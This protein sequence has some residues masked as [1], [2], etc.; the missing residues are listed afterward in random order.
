MGLSL[1]CSKRK[2][3]LVTIPFKIPFSSTI[4]IPPILCSR[5]ALLASATTAVNGNV[6]GSII[7]PLSA[8]F[9]LRTLAACCS[10][11]MFLCS[12]PIPPSLAMAIAIL[13]SVT[14]SIA[15]DTTGILIV[16][17]FVN[18]A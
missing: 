15:A 6:T 9:T 14:V 4:G 2:S 12:T 3:L 11:V 18:F 8:R 7:I 5:M 10:I 13:L 1:L 17:F 16:M